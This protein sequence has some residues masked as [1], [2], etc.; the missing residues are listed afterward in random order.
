MAKSKSFFGPRRGSTKSLTFQVVNGQQITKERVS[1]V[2]NPKTSSQAVQRMK[3]APAQKFYAAFEAVLNHAFQ[4]VQYGNKSREHFMSLAMKQNGGPYVVKG[5]NGLVPGTY[6]VA[7]GNIP[8]VILTPNWDGPNVVTSLNISENHASRADFVADVLEYNPWIM[9]GDKLTFLFVMDYD[10]VYYASKKQIVM[11]AVLSEG[12]S[13]DYAELGDTFSESDGKLDIALDDTP[14]TTTYAHTCGM[15]V[16]ISRGTSQSKDERSNARMYVN[17]D[18][19]GRFYST[20]AYEIAMASYQADSS[21]PIGDEW[22]LNN[23]AV[24]EIGRVGAR[25]VTVDRNSWQILEL[26]IT[27]AGVNKHYILVNG[28]YCVLPSGAR[29]PFQP[30]A[31]GLD[32][33]PTAP[34]SPSYLTLFSGFNTPGADNFAAAQ[35]AR[36][37]GCELSD[38]KV[39][40]VPNITVHNGSATLTAE[41]AVAFNG[42]S[43]AEGNPCVVLTLTQ[44]GQTFPAHA[45]V[46]DGRV[47]NLDDL[48]FGKPIANCD[49]SVLNV[50]ATIAADDQTFAGF[51]YA[52]SGP[53]PRPVPPAPETSLQTA[54]FL[55]GGTPHVYL[56]HIG[57]DWGNYAFVLATSPQA[58]EYVPISG[59][60]ALLQDPKDGDSMPIGMVTLVLNQTLADAI[61]QLD[62]ADGH[63]EIAVIEP[64]AD[65]YTVINGQP[66]IGVVPFDSS[67][68]ELTVKPSGTA[69]QQICMMYGVTKEGFDTTYGG[70]NERRIISALLCQVMQDPNKY[71]IA[72]KVGNSQDAK[73][74]A[75]S[76]GVPESMLD[77]A[78]VFAAGDDIVPEADYSVW[79]ADQYSTLAEVMTSN[80]FE[81]PFETVSDNIGASGYET[82]SYD[83]SLGYVGHILEA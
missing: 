50:A 8:E 64:T 78:I 67:L 45:Y 35:A 79:D 39:T 61:A 57:N 9:E 76:L 38:L 25:S 40:N 65:S 66:V 28:Q 44:E 26:I 55:L 75:V 7:E 48:N 2:K 56:A 68:S 51:P 32:G 80:T 29:A 18:I 23:F 43:Y 41:V 11:K 83:S 24:G 17:G 36:A 70:G 46:E 37:L 5:Y 15:A 33:I 27:E 49:L 19:I 62:I 20:E 60:G 82:L 13:D 54:E 52:S 77:I 74:A 71:A 47:Y 81:C 72:F 14:F 16:I 4:G 10:G 3:L 73:D 63:G 22:Y 42:R 53:R 30:S 69:L 21:N 1:E 34:W 58:T 59:I 12:E 6:L 31:A